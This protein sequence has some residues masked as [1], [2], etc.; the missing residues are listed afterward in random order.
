MQEW[1]YPGGLA[2]GMLA[3]ALLHSLLASLSVK[4][5][6]ALRWPR[7]HARYRLYYNLVAILT[8]I[9]LLAAVQAYPGPVLWRWSG[10]AFWLAQIAAG[11]ALLLFIGSLRLYRMNDF[12]GLGRA[13]G[14]PCAEP[15]RISR[16]HCFVRHPWYSLILVMLWTRDLNAAQ[17]VVCVG[18]TLYF[19]LGSRLEEAKLIALYGPAYRRFCQRVPGL[20]PWRGQ[21]LSQAEA[22]ALEE[23]ARRWRQAPHGETQNRSSC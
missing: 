9:P 15:L 18:I 1:M 5:W 22:R 20:I 7:L 12:L 3:Y 10:S 2:V 8:L 14:I 23:E 11:A 21:A 16:Y 17:L 13:R 4:H 19:W 6:V